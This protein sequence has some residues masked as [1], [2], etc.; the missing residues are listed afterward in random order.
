MCRSY[1]F[2][3]RDY[4]GWRGLSLSQVFLLITLYFSQHGVISFISV[5]LLSR[6]FSGKLFLLTILH[7][8][9]Q[10][11]SILVRYF[12]CH[13]FLLTFLYSSLHGI[14]LLVQCFTLHLYIPLGIAFLYYN[15]KIENR[16]QFIITFI[17]INY[18]F[19]W[20]DSSD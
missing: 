11:V 6:S 4:K 2:L 10:V 5:L 9:W 7:S 18:I 20:K 15:M 19:S 1:N 16:S 13:V 14:F 8:T 17:V 3:R 12:P